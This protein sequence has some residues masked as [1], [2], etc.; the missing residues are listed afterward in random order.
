VS[1]EPLIAND[2]HLALNTPATFYQLHL[3]AMAAGFDVIGSTFPGAPW[4][5]LGQN[6]RMGWGATVNPMDVTDT[7]EE[8]LVP[9]P[10]SPSGLST[11]Y[12]GSPEPV[13]PLPQLF[14]YNR[15]DGI[16]DNLATAPPGGTVG[17]TFI[18]AAVL[19]VPRRNDGPLVAVDPAAGF[20]LSVQYTGFSGTRELEAFRSLNLATDLDESTSSRPASSCSMSAR[21][22]LPMPTS[23]ATSPTSPVPRCRCARICRPASLPGC[24]RCSSAPAPAATSGCR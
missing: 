20:G 16:P 5:I 2:P 18:P 19:I 13:L 11:I 1:G 22:T 6:R 17:G 23:T 12:Q 4:I 15:F 14:R 9:D 21:R 10:G 24:R 8:Q 7:F 3:R